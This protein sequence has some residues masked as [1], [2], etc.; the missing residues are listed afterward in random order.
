[1][2]ITGG[3]NQC[4]LIP[5]CV[6]RDNS[7]PEARPEPRARQAGPYGKARTEGEASWPLRQ[8]QNRGRGKP[9]PT[10]RPEPEAR[11]A[12]PYGKASFQFDTT[13]TPFGMS[14]HTNSVSS[15][16][17][18]VITMCGCTAQLIVLLPLSQY[19]YHGCNEEAAEPFMTKCLFVLLSRAPNRPA[20][21]LSQ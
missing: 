18:V 9:A 17:E 4:H 19:H 11:Q 10:A 8:G 2:N 14:C 3:R 7:E 13:P 5:T 20:R 1:M 21:Y 6:Q 16:L 12:G 15:L